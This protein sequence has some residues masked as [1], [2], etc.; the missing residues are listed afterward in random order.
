MVPCVSNMELFQWGNGEQVDTE[1]IGSYLHHSYEG[2]WYV[3]VA[4]IICYGESVNGHWGNGKSKQ[5]SRPLPPHPASFLTPIPSKCKTTCFS[6]LWWQK[7]KFCCEECHSLDSHW[8]SNAPGKGHLSVSVSVSF[9]S[10]F[11]FPD[12]AW[13]IGQGNVWEQMW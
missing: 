7:T 5:I 8:E 3:L 11:T 9:I 13:S 2:G 4:T 1:P 12:S 10:A 6:S